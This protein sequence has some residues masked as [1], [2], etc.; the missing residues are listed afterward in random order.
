[1]ERRVM[2]HVILSV[3]LNEGPEESHEYPH[4]GQ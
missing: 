2:N 3:H 1:M 4:D